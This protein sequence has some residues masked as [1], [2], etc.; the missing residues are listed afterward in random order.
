MKET[1]KLTNRMVKV[2]EMNFSRLLPVFCGFAAP[3]CGKAPPY[4]KA[5][6]RFEAVPPFFAAEA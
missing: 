3:Q 4:R 5:S 2:I 6:L 1:L